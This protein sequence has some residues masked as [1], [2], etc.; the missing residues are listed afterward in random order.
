MGLKLCIS[1]G[2]MENKANSNSNFVTHL[3]ND[4]VELVVLYGGGP[5]HK[6]QF[7]DQVL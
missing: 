3:L 2:S 7:R 6:C 5:G 4:I 1:S